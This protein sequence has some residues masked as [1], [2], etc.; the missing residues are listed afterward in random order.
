MKNKFI[1]A[2]AELLKDKN[3]C[4]SLREVTIAIFILALLISWI[5]NQFFGKEV[6]EHMFYALTSLVAAGCFGYSIEKK[7]NVESKNEEE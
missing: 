1:N 2:L 4:H 7:T 5:A 6:P 3:G